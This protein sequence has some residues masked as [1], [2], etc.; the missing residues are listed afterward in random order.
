M[1]ITTPEPEGLGGSRSALPPRAARGQMPPQRAYCPIVT[2]SVIPLLV[3]VVPVL[4][5]GPA[6]ATDAP[7]G[8]GETVTIPASRTCTGPVLGKGPSKISRA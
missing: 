1:V 4:T 8:A 7:A 3:S 5:A 2:I 6:R